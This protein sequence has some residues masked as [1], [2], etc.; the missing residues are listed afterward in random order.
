MMEQ[1]EAMTEAQKVRGGTVLLLTGVAIVALLT[2]SSI[3]A[4]SFR[5]LL[6]AVGVV[7]IVLGVLSVGTSRGSV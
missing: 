5:V 2:F 1:F 7:T 3:Q 4:D 6:G